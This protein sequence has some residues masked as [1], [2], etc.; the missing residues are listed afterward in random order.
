[1][2]APPETRLDVAWPES[3]SRIPKDIFQRE[4]VYER[5]LER[6]FYGP[7][8][9]MI[10]HVAELPNPGDFKTISLGELP[11]VVVRGADGRVR[12]FQ[13]SCPHRGT[14]LQ[15]CTRGSAGAKIECPYH[16]WTFD[17][18]GRLLGAP[19]IE[20]FPPTF[21]KEEFGLRELRSEVFAGLVFAT[22]AG[23]APELDA[24]LG[25]AK[26]YVVRA[27]ADGAPLRLLGYQKTIFST[28]WKEYGDQ[29]GYHAPLLHRAFRLLR[30]QRG[31]GSLAVTR[32][33]HKCFDAHIEA[34]T[35]EFLN[36][37]SLIACKDRPNDVHSTIVALFPGIYTAIRHLDVINVRFAFPRSP[38][39][40]ESHYA[41][42]CRADDDEEIVRHRIRQAANFLGP[43]GFVSL[44]DGAVFDRL[45]RGSKTRG[46]VEF[47]RGVRGR[48]EPPFAVEQNDE[49]SNL[50]KWE[51]YREI[52]G[53]ART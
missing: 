9:H 24:Y 44:E 52:M 19:G 39:A 17:T 51:R 4:D 28:N 25:E 46:T 8:W 18:Q 15:T 27:L 38:H 14:Q 32:Y 11:V 1:M 20:A 6:I 16:R 41:Y 34:P 43:S 10:A 26:D 50:V 49:A 33:G 31:D 53:F 3:Y 47:Q 45:H 36:D 5:E 29:D 2:I 48:L 21:R 30:W 22:C 12:V 23:D 37:P 42:F 7:E 13:N 40:T 35:G